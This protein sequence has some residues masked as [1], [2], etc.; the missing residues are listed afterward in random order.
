MHTRLYDN[1]LLSSGDP[2]LKLWMT[3]LCGVRGERLKVQCI[4]IL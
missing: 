3:W 2:S 4:G 1:F